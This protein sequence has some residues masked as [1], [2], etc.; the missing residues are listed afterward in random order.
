MKHIIGKRSGESLMKSATQCHDIST[1]GYTSKRDHQVNNKNKIG[2][3]LK[4]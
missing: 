4:H 2:V 3:K 1:R